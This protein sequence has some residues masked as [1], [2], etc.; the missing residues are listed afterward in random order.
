MMARGV[1]ARACCGMMG[2]VRKHDDETGAEM[3]GDEEE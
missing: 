2:N 1:D 3:N